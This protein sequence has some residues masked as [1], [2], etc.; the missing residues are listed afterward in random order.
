MLGSSRSSRHWLGV[1]TVF[2]IDAGLVWLSFFLGTLVRFGEPAGEMMAR[3]FPGIA[4]ASILLPSIFYVGGL[5]SRGTARD[6]LVPL[7]WYFAG[8]GTVALIAMAMGTID[9]TARIGRGVL[10]AS[11]GFLFLLSGLHHGWLQ[12]RWTSRWRS[13]VCLVSSPSDEI[14][15]SFLERLW[16]RQSKVLGTI[17]GGDYQ[18]GNHLPLLGRI[19]EISG[20]DL[21]GVDLVLVRDR[22]LADPS[23]GPLLRQLRYRGVEIVSLADACE[24]AYR[25]VPLDLVT[26]SWLF[27]A[28]GQSDLF[29]IKKLKRGF[30]V[31]VSLLLSLPFAPV[32]LA[33]M[34]AVRLSSPGPVF[35]RQTREGRMGR[36]FTVYKLRTM[37]TDAEAQGARWSSESD[38]RVFPAG[39]WLRKFRVD[40]IPQLLNVLRGDMSFV[41]P[42]PEQPE[43]VEQLARSVPWYRER[44]LIQPGLTGWAQVRYPY[45]ATVEDAARK[46][47]YD[48]YYMKHMSLLLDCF[49]LLETI[50][51]VVFGGVPSGR[52]DDYAGFRA[53]LKPMEEESGP[54]QAERGEAAGAL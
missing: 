4:L 50:K 47:E 22:H 23:F 33:G 31:A 5:Y 34:A 21:E 40:E 28:C 44:L 35:F 32:L 29:Y 10:A 26:E 16:R 52:G 7:R 38:P 3:Y 24:E 39:R 53:E 19:G 48:L 51:I 18:P 12:R 46:L 9:Y 11:F 42:R 45:G 17:A 36:R 1:A 43:F 49:I 54:R 27:R 8:L 13:A 2:L 15:A 37:S 6:H 41:G 25:A 20:G 30:D 14:L